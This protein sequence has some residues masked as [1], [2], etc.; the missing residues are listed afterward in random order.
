MQYTVEPVTEG[1]MQFIFKAN[2][3]DTVS[4]EDAVVC[5]CFCMETAHMISNALNNSNLVDDQQKSNSDD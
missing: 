4:P 5:A 2:V 1:P 3:M